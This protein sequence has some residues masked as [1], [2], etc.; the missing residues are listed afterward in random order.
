MLQASVLG[1]LDYFTDDEVRAFNA[2]YQ[3]AFKRA[4]TLADRNL[5]RLT[6]GRARSQHL[7]WDVL[8]RLRPS[9]G[10]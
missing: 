4:R 3:K 1:K 10:N 8:K 9:P 5:K 2:E 6:C 7:C